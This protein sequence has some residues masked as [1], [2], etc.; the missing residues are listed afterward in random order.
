MNAKELLEWLKA[1]KEHVK[2][3]ERP[4]EFQHGQILSGNRNLLLDLSRTTN[5]CF[6]A[7]LDRE[8][9]QYNLLLNLVYQSGFGHTN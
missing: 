2:R 8:H 6:N 5:F 4:M 9:G 7:H 1:R 3:V